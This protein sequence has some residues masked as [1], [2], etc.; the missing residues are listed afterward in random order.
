M[1][2]YG[3]IGF[4]SSIAYRALGYFGPKTSQLF[5]FFTYVHTSNIKVGL[6]GAPRAWE[7]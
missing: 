5:L 7:P 3:W 4:L 2:G 6:R 1:G